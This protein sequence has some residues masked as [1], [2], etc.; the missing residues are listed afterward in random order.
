MK[1]IAVI[2]VFVIAEAIGVLLP[3]VLLFH[4]H[5]QWYIGG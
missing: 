4:N 3:V 5:L 1:R 2:I